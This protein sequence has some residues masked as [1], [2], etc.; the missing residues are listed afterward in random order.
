PLE[1]VRIADTVERFVER[2]VAPCGNDRFKAVAHGLRRQ[3]SR[4]ARR[5]G[6]KQRAILADACQ[7]FAKLFCLLALRRWIENHARAHARMFD[8]RSST[9]KVQS[10]RSTF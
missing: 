1:S 8:V 2:S 5:S 9:F 6:L 3:R 7:E 4:R 10:S